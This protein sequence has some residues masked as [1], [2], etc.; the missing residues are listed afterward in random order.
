MIEMVTIR[1]VTVY[2]D[3]TLEPRLVPHFLS[4]GA[5]GYTVTP[6]R[7]R[8]EHGEHSAPMAPLSSTSSHVRIELI[9]QPD[10]ALKIMVFLQANHLKSQSVAA[11][12]EDVQVV[13]TEHF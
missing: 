6:C 4:L 11:C 10:V 1:R 9:V 5:T 3:A 2:A 8:G 7:G 13:S 12:M